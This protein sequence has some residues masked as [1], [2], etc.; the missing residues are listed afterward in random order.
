MAAVLAAPVIANTVPQNKNATLAAVAA[1]PSLDTWATA[2]AA[3][4]QTTALTV[5]DALIL[6]QGLSTILSCGYVD[7]NRF[8][9]GTTAVAQQISDSANENKAPGASA[10]Q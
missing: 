8:L 5:A 6:V 10:K 3:L 2:I 4:T 1:G 9:T 7:G